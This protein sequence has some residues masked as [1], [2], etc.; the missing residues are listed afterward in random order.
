M[1]ASSIGFIGSGRITRLLLLALKEKDSLPEKILAADP[2]AEMRLKVQLIDPSRIQCVQK[3]SDA[4]DVDILFL[5]VHPPVFKEIAAEISGKINPGTIVVSLIPVISIEK[6]FAMI[7]SP[8]LVRMIPNAPSLIHQGFNPV[9]F[10]EKIT[11]DEKR[12]LKII[13][14]NWGEAPEVDEKK[15]EAYAIVT[16]MGPTYFWFQ[17][18]HLEELGKQF[19]MSD[20]EVNKAMSAM[21]HGATEILF[22]SN[23][24]ARDVLD[25][26]PVCPLKEAESGIQ[27]VFNNNL[28]GL[29]AKL[30]Q[31]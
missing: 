30:T 2:D 31:K 16:A 6:I 3:N 5:A 17:W 7:G 18:L 11:Q 24:A 25:L 10:S 20:T 15:L 23:L 12:H 14:R 13:F 1:K 4:L 26:I 21:L 9:V 29:Y 19:G 27:D 28:T 22:D 8:K